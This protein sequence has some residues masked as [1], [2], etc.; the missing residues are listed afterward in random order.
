M[1]IWSPH[2][3]YLDQKG[4]TACWRETLLAKHVLEGKTKGYKNHP[5]LIR[6]KK[7]IERDSKLPLY[8]INYYLSEIYEEARRRNYNYSKEKFDE[9]IVKKFSKNLE[10][11]KII[12]HDEQL[13]YEWLHLLKKLE[14]RDPKKYQ[15][16]KTLK[17][18]E[19]HPHPLF[20]VVEGKI[21]KWEV[22]TK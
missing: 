22:I 16:L 2:P 10:Q 4:L 19:I 6:F 3:K 20:K 13:E 1:R 17:L 14:I 8:A 9:S 7:L 15:E 12:L 18:K 21:E 11:N 5:Q